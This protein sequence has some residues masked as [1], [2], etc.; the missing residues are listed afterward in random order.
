M[1]GSQSD[2][3]TQ[4]LKMVVPFR[5]EFGKNLDIDSLL[6]DQTYADSVFQLALTSG[7]ERLREQAT[8]LKRMI[9]GPREG[10][11][12]RPSAQPPAPPLTPARPEELR[13][14]QD[15]QTA[16]YVRGLR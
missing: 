5:R 10:L 4:A 1:L 13:E 8:Y 3:I 15:K 12:L 2:V 6:S 9:L 16:K 7:N 14:F 11:A